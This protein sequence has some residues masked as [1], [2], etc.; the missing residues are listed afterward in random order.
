M[1]KPVVV[2]GATGM[3]GAM[4]LDVFARDPEFH[5]VATSRTDE[6]GLHAQQAKSWRRLDAATATVDDCR[7]VLA[8]ASWVVNC[9]GIT[10]PLIVDDDPFKV[11]RALRVNSQFPHTL[12]AAAQ[13]EGA[14][15][16]QIATDCV[17]SGT[18]GKYRES[19]PHDALDVY[20]KTKS[21]GEVA[22]SNVHHLRASIIGP[23]PKE[24][25][26]L[27][28]W[29]LGQPRAATVNGFINHDWNGVTTLAFA[30]VASGIARADAVL[31]TLQHLVPA[32]RLTK[33]DMLAAFARAY[34]RGDV[35]INNTQAS[36]VIDRTLVTTDQTTNIR[37]WTN[38][39]YAKPPTVEEMI[40]EMALFKPHFERALAA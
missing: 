22:S 16:I 34:G 26:F 9:I 8:N 39:G 33:A 27:L 30:R 23:E 17:Y 21:L 11:E 4:V 29:F 18:T 31:P 35:K 38:G 13:A 40:L 24:H 1:A 15:V 19:D 10:K 12:A 37:L 14:R 7:R 6:L 32:D 5:V 2:L 28:D 20:G 36:A 25:K 3:L